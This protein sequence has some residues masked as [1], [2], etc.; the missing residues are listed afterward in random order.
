M[1]QKPSFE[2]TSTAKYLAKLDSA[3][4]WLSVESDRAAQYRRLIRESCE[5]DVRSR[6]H[7]LAYAESREIADIL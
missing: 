4:E 6:D 2:K 7:I 5:K 1:V 3:C